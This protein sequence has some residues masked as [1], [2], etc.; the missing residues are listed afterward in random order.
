M[1]ILKTQV[2][3]SFK[4]ICSSQTIAN[5]YMPMLIQKTGADLSTAGVLLSSG[6]SNSHK[7]LLGNM[8]KFL[9]QVRGSKRHD[10]MV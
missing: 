9:S 1:L 2:F 4:F 10:C 6:A 5:V 8:Q 3:H 7:D